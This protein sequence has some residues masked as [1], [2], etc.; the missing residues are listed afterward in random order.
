MMLEDDELQLIWN[1]ADQFRDE[2]LGV[3]MATKSS[4]CPVCFSNVAPVV[5]TRDGDSVCSACGI[6]VDH[7]RIDVVFDDFKR[8]SCNYVG[9]KHIFHFNERVANLACDDPRI[10]DDLFALVEVAYRDRCS[11]GGSEQLWYESV[12]EVLRSVKVPDPL[13]EKYRGKRYKKLPMTDMEQKFSERWLTIRYR[14]TGSRPPS[15]TCSARRGI[16]LLFLGILAPFNY[17]RHRDEC[18]KRH[19]CHKKFGCAYKLPPYNF[20]M[21]ELFFVFGGKEL[22]DI[23]APFLLHTTSPVSLAKIK[24]IW[25]QIAHYNNWKTSYE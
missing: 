3:I 14:L 24:A 6:V 21:K 16:Q 25:D 13:Q 1:Q 22:L 5:S 7:G 10:P 2:T 11:T 23:Y 20:I 9:Y 19:K 4:C 15:I 12:R 18:D 17:I 8:S